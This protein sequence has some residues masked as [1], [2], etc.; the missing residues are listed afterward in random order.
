MDRWNNLLTDEQAH[1]PIKGSAFEKFV[2]QVL[3]QILHEVLHKKVRPESLMEAQYL[4]IK[5]LTS[6]GG[7]DQEQ[8]QRH[9]DQ[10]SI[11]KTASTDLAAAGYSAEDFFRKSPGFSTQEIAQIER[12]QMTIGDVM[13][14]RPAVLLRPLLA[15]QKH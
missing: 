13:D 8:Y 4:I 2:N 10:L 6:Q 12:G 15:T 3:P 7:A 9:Q 14:K 1:I 11:Y 5:N